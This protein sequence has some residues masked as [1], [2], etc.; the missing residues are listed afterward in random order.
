[1]E[2]IAEDKDQVLSNIKKKALSMNMKALS[3]VVLQ[4][5]GTRTRKFF[6]EVLEKDSLRY[7]A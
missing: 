6:A 7:V 1:M 3:K 4:C 5:G 2:R